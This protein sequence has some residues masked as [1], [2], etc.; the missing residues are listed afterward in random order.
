MALALQRNWNMNVLRD[1]SVVVMFFEPTCK[2]GDVGR[3][4]AQHFCRKAGWP[5][6]WGNREQIL[7]GHPY[8]RV[9]RDKNLACHPD[10][11][12]EITY[13]YPMNLTPPQI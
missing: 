10:Q 3:P 13:N 6:I 8:N 4:I 9:S 1:F 12:I 2:A 11:N 5:Y 7:T